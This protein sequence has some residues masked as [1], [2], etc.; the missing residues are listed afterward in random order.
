MSH[1]ADEIRARLGHPVIDADGHFVE[2]MPVLAKFLRAEGIADATETF[3]HV[4]SGFGTT[5]YERLSPDERR[6]RRAVRC[7]WWAFPAENTLD[8]AT[9][10]LPALLHERL[11][12]L[13]IDFAVLYPSAGL[14]YAHVQDDRMRN[15]ACR[16]LN[17]YSAEVF[18][19]YADRVT[20]AAVIPM[21]TP[22]EAIESLE[23]A[24]GELGL[25]AVMIAGFVERP[26][27]DVAG[28]AHNV[29]WDLYGIDSAHDYDPFWKRCIELG[30]SPAAHSGA[31]GIGFR[32]SLGNY[33]F[34]HV[35]HFGAA[36]EALCKALF[37][38]GVTRRFPRLRVAFLEGGVHWAVG[39]LADVVARW[40]KRGIERVG[41]YDPARID[42]ARFAALVEEHGAKLLATL[43]ETRAFSMPSA[44]QAARAIDDFEA[45]H[46][47]WREDLRDAFV[48]NFYF[49][50]EA[51]DPMT[52]TA[53]RRQT[54]PFG[55]EV[56]AMFSS[57]IGH[58]D[59][60]DMAEVLE[61]AYENVE[62]GW[63]DAAQFR[64][65]SFE[66]VA[67]FYTDANPRFFAGTHV[68]SEVRALLA[69]HGA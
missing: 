30:V 23:L 56:H 11:P 19:D 33:M 39:L 12:A 38:G 24:V 61:E 20:P 40:E 36:G 60:P 1:S 29:W 69:R 67:R 34:N 66:N 26:V 41:R 44:P 54:T 37:M 32:R 5:Q 16:A 31:M 2:F 6:A 8:L 59:V 28:G 43:G 35:G 53:F 4:S 63:L 7:P 49:G 17:R 15:A 13:G 52:P 9:A 21:H 25:R 64:A 10:T 22:A 55:V 14:T 27:E 57:D 68:E 62:K 18:G 47:E 50:C 58:W 42:P 48:P 45:M 51:D 65:F 3:L 46:L